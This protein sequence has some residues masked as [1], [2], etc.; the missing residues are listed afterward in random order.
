MDAIDRLHLDFPFMGS[1]QLRS[2]LRR[3]GHDAGRLRIR[4]LM[5]KMGISALAPQFGSSCRN[6]KH[7]VFPY[8]LHKLAIK[9][10]NHV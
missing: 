8:L 10:S 5:R 4:T 1:N 6:P 7:K 9:R 3:Q 2:A